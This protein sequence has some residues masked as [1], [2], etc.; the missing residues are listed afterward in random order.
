MPM[1]L[2]A[3]SRKLKHYRYPLLLTGL[4]A[5]VTFAFLVLPEKLH[6][7]DF[8]PGTRRTVELKL[9]PDELRLLNN[10]GNHQVWASV[11]MVGSGQKSYRL[12]IRPRRDSVMDFQ[13]NIGETVYNLFK[14]DKERK[15]LYKLF[16]QADN[17]N[18][19]HSAPT[20]LRLNINGVFIGNYLMEPYTYEQVRDD[21]DR[22][23]I[24]LNTDTHLLRRLRYEIENGLKRTLE[25]TFDKKELAAYLVF[26]SLFRP[27]N[28][29]DPNFM[30]FQY[31]P[32][33]K[34][35]RPYVTMDGIISSLWKGGKGKKKS[36]PKQKFPKS[37]Y[38]GLNRRNIDNLLEK[39][40]QL[41]YPR[42]VS[43]VLTEIR[44]TITVD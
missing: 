10:R 36:A 41:S 4:L 25:K 40:G 44:P 24:R 26:F 35:F 38:R 37:F 8:E 22:Y 2:S 33:L 23:F 14:L 31:E 5:V 1:K 27:G 28:P 34:R 42:L 39:S 7:L 29:P 16:K 20:R 15:P 9:S 18:L 12:K 30:V 17:W 32:E 43:T 19:P 3:V 11:K 13:V 6:L 21:G